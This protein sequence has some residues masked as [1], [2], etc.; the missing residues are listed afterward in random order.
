MCHNYTGGCSN[1]LHGIHGENDCTTDTDTCTVTAKST[2]TT[3]DLRSFGNIGDNSSTSTST[4]TISD[5]WVRNLSKT[6]LTEAQEHLLAHG[7]NFVLV[8]K[9]PPTC[10]YIAATEKACQ[11]LMQGK[12]EELRGEIKSLLKKNHDTKPNI[13]KEECQA[14]KQVKNDN[15]R[16]VLTADMGV[17]MV[18]VEREEYIYKS[19]ELLHQPNYK[20]LQSDPTNK[21]INKLISLLKSI[22]PEGGMDENTYRRLYPTGAGPPKYYGLPK[23]HR[24]RMPLRLIISSIGSLT[25]ATAKE[26][27]RILKHLVGKSSHH[28]KNNMDFIESL[29]GIQLQPGESMVSFDVEAL[30][31]SVPIESAISIIKKHLE[32]DKD[33]HQ[34]TAMTVKQITCLLEFCLRTNYFTFQG[35]MYE[36]VKGAAMG[37]PIS[38]IVANLFMED[39]DSKAL[40]TAPSTPKIWKGLWMIHSLSSKEHRKMPSLNISTP[41]I[42]IFIS[43]MK[44][45]K[46]MAPYLFLICW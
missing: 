44:I 33:L 39:L 8:P 11:H 35:K 21:Y 22:K 34:R 16:M 26:L 13:L 10:K 31:T 42:P 24:P 18:V 38:P 4:Y 45:R 41:L 43:H 14:L 37:S 40:A 12:A 23:V 3:V 46:K 7:P 25:H 6:P 20:I 2:N 32:E 30:F 1:P 5:N 27:S 17:S 28:V 9:D 29:K 15:T 19:E 36:Q